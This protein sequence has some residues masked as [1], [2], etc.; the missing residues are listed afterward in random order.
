MKYAI[1]NT[2][3]QWWTGSCWGVIQA[4]EEYTFSQLPDSLPLGNLDDTTIELNS[5]E[6]SDY[7]RACY[8]DMGE[9]AG[10]DIAAHIVRV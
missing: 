7:P 2:S 9:E 6:L 5:D 10:N 8:C 3:G 4:R 1:E